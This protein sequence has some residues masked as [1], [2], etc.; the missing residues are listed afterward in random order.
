M[1]DQAEPATDYEIEHDT[2]GETCATCRYW[3]PYVA[4]GGEDEGWGACD[5]PQ[6]PGALFI[7]SDGGTLDTEQGF[8]CSQYEPAD[9][10]GASVTVPA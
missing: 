3:E 2:V 10:E 1:S 5:R 7:C 4:V 6:H 8:Y 9:E